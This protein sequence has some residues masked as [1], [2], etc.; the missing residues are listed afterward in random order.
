MAFC[1]SEQSWLAPKVWHKEEGHRGLCPERA[2]LSRAGAASLSRL[3]PGG[4]KGEP[5]ARVGAA[6][7]QPHPCMAAPG[8][9]APNGTGQ[10]RRDLLQLLSAPF[11]GTSSSS[12][13]TEA[14]A[15]QL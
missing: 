6:A 1:S 15:C 2:L 13:K 11:S 4:H 9:A 14:F 3:V 5:D 10:Q 8:S 12:R 7:P